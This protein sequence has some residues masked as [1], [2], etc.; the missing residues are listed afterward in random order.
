METVL[1]LIECVGTVS[2]AVSGTLV[3]IGK[4][5]DIIGALIF[6]LLTSFGGGLLRDIILGKLPPSVFVNERFRVLLVICL[7]A[8][9][10]CCALACFGRNPMRIRE[11]RHDLWLDL[12]DAVGISVFCISGVDTAIEVVGGSENALLLVFCGCITGV[13]GGILRDVF[14]AEIPFIFRKYVY[15]IP[16]VVGSAF[17]TLTYGCISHYTGMLVSMGLIIVL[18]TLAIVFKWN[19]PV[20]GES[21]QRDD[22]VISRDIPQSEPEAE[23]KCRGGES[24]VEPERAEDA[25]CGEERDGMGMTR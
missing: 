14:S 9:L 19:F 24:G 11:H 23:L 13:G 15:L 25:M 21:K 3:A 12:T 6:A 8:S 17:Y 2:F 4:R 7:L 18:R 10:L 20:L 22:A 1:F 5:T 16:T